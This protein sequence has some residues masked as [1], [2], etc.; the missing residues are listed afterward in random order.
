MIWKL[1]NNK[2]VHIFPK[3]QETVDCLK[4][5]CDGKYLALGCLD[6][7]LKIFDETF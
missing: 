4:F 7:T 5:S 1:G 2:P 6:S 3:N